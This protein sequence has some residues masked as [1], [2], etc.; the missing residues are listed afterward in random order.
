MQDKYIS[1]NPINT[2]GEEKNIRKNLYNQR[3]LESQGG[4]ASLQVGQTWGL[5][6][7]VLTYSLLKSKESFKILPY[8]AS[9]ITPYSKIVGAYF[10]FF[11]FGK[12]FVM[13]KFGDNKLFKH[14]YFN[15][16]AILSGKKGFEPEN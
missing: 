7:A 4:E 11:W 16:S 2:P 5:T 13:E 15:K 8:Q 12:S 1:L 10:L 6:A 3:L 14:L 9:K